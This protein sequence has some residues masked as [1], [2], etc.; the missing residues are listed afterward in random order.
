MLKVVFM[1]TPQ[2]AVNSIMKLLNFADIHIMA[3]VTQPDRPSGRGKKL[4]AP[5]VKTC[6]VTNG[7]PVY[8]TPSIRKDREL[9]ETL[10]KLEPDFFI[11]FA[12]GQIL[13]QEVLDIP[14]YATINLHASLL[15][16][17]RGANPIQRALQNGDKETGITTMITALALD[18]GDICLQEKIPITE[19]MTNKDLEEIISDKSPFLLYRTLKGL[20]SGA[21]I[22]Y[23]QD[24]SEVTFAN[25]FDK[26]DAFLDWN[27]NACDIHNQIRCMVD[28]P[29][30][31]TKFNGK[32]VKVLESRILSD[33]NCEDYVDGEVVEISKKGVTVRAGGAC[34][35]ITKVKPESKGE[36]SAYDWSNGAKIKLGDRFECEECECSLEE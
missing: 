9:I 2:I 15:P 33:I 22:P 1:G 11:T 7:I 18:S 12:F 24:E 6:A 3:V 17:Y 16:K 13:S 14:K 34:I 32:V 30:A 25:K 27:K 10:K 19:N 5:P 23:P 4:M 28:W 26:Q 35:L 29:C 20:A 8:Q 36:M 21:I 31:C